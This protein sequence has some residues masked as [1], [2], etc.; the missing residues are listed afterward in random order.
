MNPILPPPAF[1]VD[2]WTTF[3]LFSETGEPVCDSM[4]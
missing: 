3:N 1:T 2:Q 4:P